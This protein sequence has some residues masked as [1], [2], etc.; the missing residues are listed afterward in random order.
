MI[1]L[2]RSILS[3]LL[4]L[5]VLPSGCDA[6][7]SVD[8]HADDHVDAPSNRIDVP[9]LVRQNLGIEFTAVQR[10]AVTST[11]RLPAR[12]ELL[13]TATHHYRAPM[14][15]RV[16]LHVEP[17]QKVAP[18]DLLYTL[19]SPQWRLRQRELG[20]LLRDREVNAARLDAMQPLLQACELHETSLRRA[21][22]VA[23]SYVADL[24]QAQ[25]DI[26]GQSQK[27]ATARV[28]LGRLAAQIAEAAEKHV[29][30]ETRIRE[31]RA[32]QKANEQQFDLLLAGA[33]ATLGL[34]PAALRG[35]DRWNEMTTIEVRATQAGVVEQ[36][37][38]S[39]GLFV[40]QHAAVVVVV[41]PARVRCRARALQSD[42]GELRD[43]LQADI[44]PAAGD[45]RR[46]GAAVQLA[47]IADAQTRTVEL[48]VTPT[49]ATDWLRPGLAVFVEVVTSTT[50]EAELAI[51][52]AC[53][54]PDGTDRVFF[55]R[56]PRDPDKVI[57]V[58]ADAGATDGEWVEIKSGVI[59]GDEVVSAGAFELVLASGDNKPKGGHFHADGTWHADG[60]DHE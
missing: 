35:D 3:L 23:E 56:D 34:E 49:A 44:V 40:D 37:A 13:P 43:G 39:N 41:D 48:F 54:L 8:D 6:P 57:R 11:M 12:V 4:P 27:I 47:P 30:T 21:H 50:A 17:L 18:G 5:L 1:P 51:P 33:A 16:L 10:R 24:E 22:E 59:E 32:Q 20:E 7:A 15:G 38:A 55:L 58:V 29:E 19:D 31:L 36:I 2:P 60:E 45:A 26:G 28:D 52:R 53:L 9:E 14:A 42:L 25:A 46:A